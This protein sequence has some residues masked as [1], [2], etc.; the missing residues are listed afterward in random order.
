MSSLF[1]Q[2]FYTGLAYPY[3]YFL[4]YTRCNPSRN[5]ISGFTGSAVD[6]LSRILIAIITELS[7]L[8]FV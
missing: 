5:L 6:A 2:I 8:V 1:K 3:G 4:Y 7:G